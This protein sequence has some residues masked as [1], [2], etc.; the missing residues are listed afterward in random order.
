MVGDV[1]QFERHRFLSEFFCIQLLV[2]KSSCTLH[3]TIIHA[4]ADEDLGGYNRL[5]NVRRRS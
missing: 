5:E 4:S 1:E 2:F 3:Q